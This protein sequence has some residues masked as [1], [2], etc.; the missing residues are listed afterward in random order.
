MH[1]GE[2]D[3]KVVVGQLLVED[4][5]RHRLEPRVAGVLSREMA[6]R[7]GPAVALADDVLAVDL[8]G[9]PARAG[10]LSSSPLWSWPPP[11]K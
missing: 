9:E 5:R 2:H 4:H 11:E 7:H 3:G 8:L 6:R 10:Q 1:V